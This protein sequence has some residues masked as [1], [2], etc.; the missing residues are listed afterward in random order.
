MSAFWMIEFESGELACEAVRRLRAQGHAEL[1]LHAPY[2]VPGAAEALGIE[3]PRYLPRLVLGFALLGA[4]TG[5]GLQWYSS[6]ATPD[7]LAGARPVH[8]AP[9]F[10]PVTFEL[11]VLFGSAAAFVG[12]FARWPSLRLW[13]PVFEVEG[14]E[15]ASV[16]RYWVRVAAADPGLDL[17]ELRQTLAPLE[18]LRIERLDA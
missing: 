14:F 11:G 16:D 3:R 1:D 13:Q 10:V 5:Y 2:E 6:V 7:G 4:L 18:P 17:E 15:R 9:A 8:A 12:L